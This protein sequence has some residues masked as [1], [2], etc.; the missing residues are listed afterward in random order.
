[1]KQF[2]RIVFLTA[3][4]LC[5]MY[6]LNV[7]AQATSGTI[8]GVIRSAAGSPVAGVS[9]TVRNQDNGATRRVQTDTLGRYRSSLLP[10]GSYEV[11][12]ERSGYFAAQQSGIVLRIAQTITVGLTMRPSPGESSAIAARQ[13]LIDRDRKQ[14]STTLD[15]RFVA[16]LPVRGRKF[17]DLGVL[18]SGATEFGDRETS[19]TADFSGVS[20]FYANGLVDGMDAYQAF[21]NLP[22]AKFLVPFEYN[23]SAIQEFQ[24]MAGNF[25]AEFGRSAGGLV[26]VVTR[27]GTNQWHGEASYFFMDSALNS[28]PRF[29]ATKPDTG[30]HLIGG[31][32]GGPLINDRLFIFGDYGKQIRNEPMIVSPGTVLDGSEATLASITNPD[33][34]QRFLDARDFVQSLVG[35]FDR[36][37]DQ[38]TGLIRADWRP[39][40][41]HAVSARFNYQNL[42]AT[43][44]PENGFN[45]PIVSGMAVS[46]NGRVQVNNGSLVMQWTAALSAGLLNEARMQFAPST[47][48]QIPNAPGPQVRIGSGRT[49]IAFGRRDVFPSDL[50][51]KRWQW[52]DNVTVVR[53]GHEIKTGVDVQHI[54]DRYISLTA[55]D[56]SYQFSTL[57]DFGNGRFNAYTQ[58][59]GNPEDS[60]VS[61]YYSAFV[62]DN[63]RATSNV[64]VNLGL[65]YEYQQL[66]Q[67]SKANPQLPRTGV[68]PQDKNNFAPRVGIS[69][70]P[71]SNLVVRT[72]YGIYYGPLPLQ[73]NS[74]GKTQNG[75][76][77]DVRD[78]R[79][80]AATGIVYPNVFPKNT[81]PSTLAPGASIVVFSPD[82]VAPYVQHVNLEVERQIRSDFSVS[83]GWMY[84]KGTKLRSNEDINLFPPGQ[85]VVSI[86][87]TARNISGLIAVPFFS[88][89]RPMPYF[90]QVDEFRSDNNSVYHAFVVQVN[91]RY[92]S[93]LQFLSNYTL[94]KLIDRNQAPGNQIQCCTSDNVYDVGAERGLGRRD[95]R[96]RV[97]FAA[98]WELA[99][100]LRVNGIVKA[101]SGRPYTAMITGD[102]GGD[103]NGN[104]SRGGDR[105]PFFGS[106]TFIGPGYASLDAS[107]QKVFSI[108]G[109]SV[110]VGIEA[111]NLFNRANYLRPAPEYYTLTNV[112]GGISRLDGPPPSFGKPADAMRSRELQLVARF[113]F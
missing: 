21:S 100:G 33:E 86:Q 55:V 30:E 80:P 65:R 107:I 38:Y 54:S 64:S 72:S 25:S 69:W 12:A 48:R 76:I 102:S 59:F 97:N 81:D 101:G 22:K 71:V 88:S 47:E 70:Q 99:H 13:P 93:G 84:T 67:P 61:P 95:Q 8:A 52:L 5:S 89:V 50:R 9:V 15:S 98:V 113:Y 78:F 83:T 58:G 6:P 110:H 56:G 57:R 85:R 11:T 39:N 20:H 17:L 111:F 74:V 28:I 46:N 96:H 3:F 37:I 62:Q 32:L 77:Q 23:Q 73:V 14:P 105:A 29:A 27:S 26:N 49:G 40:A 34:R 53:G 87:D 90:N 51:E 106:N 75:V 36:D 94:S 19:A 60:T 104:G 44:V 66:D 92:S 2:R 16:N 68:I 35:G 4:C 63:F 103:L 108:E 42:H 10:L 82:F 79:G 43:N 1:M 45:T 7:A 109:K 31:A 91:K 41:T 112:Q 18:V 24:V